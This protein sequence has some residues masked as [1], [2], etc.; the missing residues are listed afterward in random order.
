MEDQKP[1]QNCLIAYIL[2]ICGVWKKESKNLRA[3]WHLI[4]IAYI[5]STGI[6]MK[7]TTENLTSS[8]KKGT[9]KEKKSK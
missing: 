6:G 4:S 7:E 8:K 3:S 2:G 9:E 1:K 5:S